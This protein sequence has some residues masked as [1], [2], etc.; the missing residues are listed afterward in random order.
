MRKRWFWV[1]LGAGVLAVGVL[2]VVTRER[3]PVYGGR[4]L[5]EWVDLIWQPVPK[6]ISDERT[7]QIR[8]FN[9]TPVAIR[10]MGTNALPF[11]VT[12]SQQKNQPSSARE[13][14]DGWLARLNSKWHLPGTRQQN[15]R[16]DAARYAVFLLLDDPNRDTRLLMTNALRQFDPQALVK[17]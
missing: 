9:E 14:I 12:W 3:E 13:V 10:A 8:R 16:P 1:I 6:G 15:Y 11:L 7:Y 4:K 17:P 2:V 5:S